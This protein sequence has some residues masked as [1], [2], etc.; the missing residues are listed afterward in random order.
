[1]FGSVRRWLAPPR[2]EGDFE[3]TNAARVLHFLLLIMLVMLIA[4]LIFFSFFEGDRARNVLSIAALTAFTVFALWRLRLGHVDRVARYFLIMEWIVALGYSLVTRGILSPYPALQTIIVLLAGILLRPIYSAYFAVASVISVTILFFIS[5]QLPGAMEFVSPELYSAYAAS[6]WFVYAASYMMTATLVLYSARSITMNLERILQRD[7]Q[8]AERNRALEA[9][10]AERTR[11]EGELRQSEAKFRTLIES[12]QFGIFILKDAQHA[13]FVYVNRSFAQMLGYSPEE[14]IDRM[15]PVDVLTTDDTDDA[16]GRIQR[17]FEGRPPV[18]T[19]PYRA[20]RKDG[21]RVDVVVSGMVID[22][23]GQ[24]ALLGTMIDV[25]AERLAEGSRIELEVERKRVEFLRGFV[26]TMTHDL[27]T[28]LS[29]IGSSLYLIEKSADP[30]DHQRHLTKIGDQVGR[31]SRMIEDMLTVAR[32]DTVPDLS[33][34]NVDVNSLIAG[35]C[36][37]LEVQSQHKKLTLVYVSSPEVT[38]VRA[39]GDLLNHAV[40]NLIENAINYT[41]AG[42][43]VTVRTVASDEYVTIEVK[44]S[45]IGISETE[46]PRVFDRFFRARNAA[47]QSPGT[48]LGLA[49]TKRI[50]D[51]HAGDISVTSQVGAGS[52]FKVRL[53]AA[54][55]AVSAV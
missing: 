29:V 1:M 33:F 25:T 45:G 3:R 17:R 6:N 47:T 11:F 40:I 49:I 12:A 27:K 21:S 4:T 18:G 44:D 38:A 31:M 43:T 55:G 41:P 35:V 7:R 48:G 13:D 28:P 51:L 42:G 37:Q 23:D 10:V 32:L 15:S 34:E 54:R 14:M 52:L 36:D 16:F 50:V 2:F 8:L 9:E 30:A 22:Y 39:D 24:P 20:I 46:L 19:A 26:D 53:P 5:P